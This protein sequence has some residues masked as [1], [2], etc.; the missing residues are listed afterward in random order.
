M[1]KF[2]YWFKQDLKKPIRVNDL[3]GVVFTLDNVGSRIGVEVFDDGEPVALTGTVNGYVIIPGE[4]TVSVAGTRSNNTAYIELPQSALAT[5]GFIKIAIKLTNSSEITTLLAVVATVYKSRTDTIITPSQQIITD[6]SQQI[7]AEM[8]AV[9]DASAAQD[10]KIDDLKSAIHYQIGERTDN[11]SEE[12]WAVGYIASNGNIGTDKPSLHSANFNPCQASHAYYVNQGTNYTGTATICWYD[13][14]YALISRDYVKNTSVTSP[15]NAAYFKM[16]MYNYG[17][18]YNWDIA[19]FDG[20][21]S[22]PYEPYYTAKD[23]KA[24]SG[25]SSVESDVEAL[26]DRI[27]ADIEELSDRID[28]NTDDIE[29]IIDELLDKVYEK[30]NLSSMTGIDT[31]TDFYA[32]VQSN[33]RMTLNPNAS[34]DSY[35]FFAEQDL[36][37]YAPDVSVI[38]YYSIAI[39][40]SPNSH[41]WAKGTGGVLT[42]MGSGTEFYRKSNNNLPTENNPVSIP[43]G[44]LVCISVTANETPFLHI[45]S[46]E[47]TPKSTAESSERL[48]DVVM[49]SSSFSY[50]IP[51]SN[52]RYLRFLFNHFVDAP[53]NADG[54]VQ[55]NVVLV[56][57]DKA[58]E[59]FPVV[60]NG[61]WEMAVK[62]KDRPDFIGCQNHGSE[63]TTAVSFFFDGKKTTI[64]N[65]NELS[66]RQIVVIE[67]STMYDPNDETTVVGYHN[68]KYTITVDEIKIEQRIEWVVDDV[69]MKSYI[70]MMPAVRGN[71][72]TSATQVTSGY[73][74]DKTLTEYDISTITFAP[75]LTAENDKGRS[76]TLYGA[77]SGAFINVESQIKNMPE[78]AFSFLSNAV[79]YNKIYMAYNGDNFAIHNG[80]VWE[81]VSYY[82]IKG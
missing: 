46:G 45:F 82:R 19:V 69:A 28:E 58:T 26:S 55:R 35:A 36:S 5:P 27:D 2:E 59:V 30:I 78:S 49:G 12:V 67:K 13:S 61:E 51:A 77:T 75:Y 9:E 80:D 29:T 52:N 18:T 8:Q 72:S 10:A 33:D 23:I 76:I 15:A 21:T 73:F 81:W 79:Y 34:Y 6:W 31:K 56:G 43:N 4:T 20:N 68:K 63:I 25:L 53:S 22:K 32:N 11:I 39:L 71:D 57:N 38:D 16:S 70:L 42:I 74:D 44:A 41:T 50:Y 24:R 47:Y 7:A 17:T 14:S 1:P 40:K 60:A 3:S 54:W 66:C 65:G 37:I 62:L 48:I 64:T